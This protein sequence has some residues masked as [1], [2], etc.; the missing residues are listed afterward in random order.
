MQLSRTFMITE[1]YFSWDILWVKGSVDG[2]LTSKTFI[3]CGVVLHCHYPGKTGF[4][5]SFHE[6]EK[7]KGQ[8]LGLT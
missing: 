4:F 2:I 7:D 5:M 8:C 1:T 6:Q 3:L